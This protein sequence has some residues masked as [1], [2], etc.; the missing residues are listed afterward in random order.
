MVM[1]Q[2]TARITDGK[3][4]FDAG[5]QLAAQGRVHPALLNW[6]MQDPYL[7]QKPPKTSGRE[8]YGAPYVDAL[9]REAERLGVSPLDQLATA[10]RFTAACIRSAIENDCSAKPEKLIVGGGGSLNPTLMRM[11]ADCLPGV[12]VMR[13][14]DLGLDSNAKEAVAFAILANEYLFQH[15]GNVCRVTGAK[16]PV[17]LG[18]MSL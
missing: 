8:R 16:H 18:K 6:M 13:N 4:R 11:L 7:K 14:E 12:R 10:T 1:D 17:V 9:Q 15:C 3:L 2:L 5:G